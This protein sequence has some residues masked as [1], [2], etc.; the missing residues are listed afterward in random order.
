VLTTW[1]VTGDGREDLVGLAAIAGGIVAGLAHTGTAQIAQ[2]ELA[3]PAGQTSG[4]A[5]AV[6]PLP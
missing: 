1:S 2:T 6:L 4:R 5:L 3:V